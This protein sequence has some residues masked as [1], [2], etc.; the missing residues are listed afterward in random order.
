MRRPCPAQPDSAVW[1]SDGLQTLGE[2]AEQLQEPKPDSPPEQKPEPAVRVLLPEGV[3]PATLGR[4]SAGGFHFQFVAHPRQ[5]PFPRSDR[6]RT[7]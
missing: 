2:I 7:A 4:V 1:H 6:R 5:F 3:Q